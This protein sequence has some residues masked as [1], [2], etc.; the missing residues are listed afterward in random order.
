M[1][2]ATDRWGA[3]FGATLAL[4][5]DSALV[6][7]YV[8]GDS[9]TPIATFVFE[10][11]GS[12]WLRRGNLIGTEPGGPLVP[13]SMLALSGG[14]AA[15]RVQTNLFLYTAD[16]PRL[17]VQDEAGLALPQPIAARTMALQDGGADELTLILRNT[18]N[19][20]L[21][22]IAATVIG[23][24]AAGFIVTAPPATP[25]LPGVATSLTVRFVDTSGTFPK[26]AS[27]RVTSS[28]PARSP[29]VLNLSGI[30]LLSTAD[31]DFDGLNDV[32]EFHLRAVGFDPFLKQPTLVK[33]LNLGGLYTQSQI[34]A[35][36][37]GK[38]LLQPVSPGTFRLTLGL[39]K[40]TLLTNFT[41]FPMVPSQTT[42]NAEGQVQFE[43]TSPENVAFYLLSFE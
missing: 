16:A 34:Q 19:T 1:L 10:R 14:T 40:A 41:P 35:L 37:V 11:N 23:P 43:F 31:S 18:G 2:K 39:Q 36:T 26:Q 17:V 30:S 22:N 42:L 12:N 21:T 27:H 29:W 9:Q 3:A 28:D 6:G 4:S 15:V 8:G 5:G 7:E 13:P 32:A 25:L 38:P 33:A 20:A 24:D